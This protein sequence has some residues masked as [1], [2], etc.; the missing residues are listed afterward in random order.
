MRAR[1]GFLPPD[2]RAIER[3]RDA[4]AKA[5]TT[6]ALRAAL[7][8]AVPVGELPLRVFAAPMRGVDNKGSVL[9]ALEIDG[10]SLKFEPRDGRFAESIE[11]SIVAADERARVQGGD[12]Q[13]FNLNLVPETHER[14]SR[15][16]VRM[17]SQ[18]ELPPGRYQIRV[19]AHE[20]TGRAIGTV[21]YDLEVP[22]YAKR[23]CPEW[24]AAHLVGGRVVRDRESGVR[25]ERAA[26]VATGRDADVR[27]GGLAD[28]V[29]RGVRQLQPVG[30]HDQLHLDGAGCQGR[31]HA[32]E[33]A[34]DTRTVAAD[35]KGLAQGFT[36][37][38]PLRDFT[39]GAY[40]LRVEASPTMG[41]HSARRDILFEVR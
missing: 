14:V 30:S 11:V 2:T 12:R 38:L 33:Q 17:L 16:G 31:T 13:N 9:V 29:R 40:V 32:R 34:R 22:D 23:L 25:L 35:S 27:G 7:G 26:S 19:G 20:S 21:P 5:G 41:N 39:P 3:A 37:S 15:T 28:L 18:L 1:K 4:D 8:K 24:G 36:T 6:P 10:P